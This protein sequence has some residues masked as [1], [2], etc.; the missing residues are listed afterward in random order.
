MPAS[1][2]MVPRLKGLMMLVTARRNFCSGEKRIT[3]GPVTKRS[4]QL[5]GAKSLQTLDCT[6]EDAAVREVSPTPSTETSRK[7]PVAA[8][9]APAFLIS[10][11][12]YGLAGFAGLV[13]LLSAGDEVADCAGSAEGADADAVPEPAPEPVCPAA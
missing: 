10:H 8:M 2:T 11:V 7:P 3:T 6:A 4:Y 5:M 13:G 9:D 12:S 1:P